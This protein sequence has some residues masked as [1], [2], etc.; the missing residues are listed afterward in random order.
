MTMTGF[1]PLRDVADFLLLFTDKM[2][3]T[4]SPDHKPLPAKAMKQRGARFLETMFDTNPVKAVQL[5]AS[6]AHYAASLADD[7][8]GDLILPFVKNLAGVLAGLR[9]PELAIYAEAM[10]EPFILDPEPNAPN[11]LHP[12][13]P[14]EPEVLRHYIKALGRQALRP[15][16]TNGTCPNMKWLSQC[17]D[18]I[19]LAINKEA[20]DLLQDRSLLITIAKTR[21]ALAIGHWHE[22]G[23]GQK[24]LIESAKKACAGAWA[25]FPRSDDGPPQRPD[26]QE[27]ESIGMWYCIPHLL[28]RNPSDARRLI[29][30]LL[31]SCIEKDRRLFEADAN[32]SRSRKDERANAI[33]PKLLAL[34]YLLKR[35]H[36]GP[37]CFDDQLV[38]F[39]GKGIR[40]RAVNLVS[41]GG[42]NKLPHFIRLIPALLAWAEG[43]QPGSAR[44]PHT[45]PAHQQ[46]R[47]ALGND[48]PEQ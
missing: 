47:G 37:F 35:D 43:R 2:C 31:D 38:S 20:P 28:E 9:D 6:T 14:P 17:V 8:D 33:N 23:E 5:L 40:A 24:E 36:H 22:Y 46:A 4:E 7:R 27:L 16:K 41:G 25:V 19:V 44:R 21:C 3:A 45:L 30:E 48:A 15:D 11:T 32:V 26:K 1:L 18:R 29:K 10:L 13:Y 34:A 42:L 12:D 39:Y